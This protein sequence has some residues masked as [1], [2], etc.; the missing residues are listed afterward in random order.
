[1]KFLQRTRDSIGDFL[2]ASRE[3]ITTPDGE[4]TEG[5]KMG[6]RAQFVD[7]MRE[8]AIK[9]GM[10]PLEPEDVGT[11]RDITSEQRLGLI[12]DVQTQAATRYGDWKQGQDPDVLDEFPA[13]RFIRE[14]GVEK[15]RPVHQANEGEVRLKSD[16]EFWLAM[17]DPD[18][19]GFGVPYG[20]WGFNSGMG[21]EDVDRAEAESLGLLQPGEKVEPVEKEFNDHLK[22]SV[23]GLDPDIQGILKS[24]F[25]DQVQ[26]SDGVARWQKPAD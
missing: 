17:N 23:S 7:R 3:K 6:S 11:V 4:I 14:V 22:S 2:G 21:V 8:L 18:N 9:E 13:Q 1:M 16:L 15:P 10:G 19:G 20:P 26:I 5:L 25:G 12:F 24:R